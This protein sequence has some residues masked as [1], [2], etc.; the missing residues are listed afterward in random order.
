MNHVCA[1]TP[2]EAGIWAQ[3]EFGEAELGNVMRR[4]RLLAMASRAFERPSGVVSEVIRNPTEQEAA[5]RFLRSKHTDHQEIGRSAFCATAVRCKDEKLVIVPVDGTN[6]TVPWAHG[7][8]AF[9]PVG[10]SAQKVRGVE[11]MSAIALTEAGTPLGICGQQWWVRRDKDP[12]K[13]AESLKLRPFHQKETRY[14]LSCM[15]IS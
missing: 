6:I 4:E 7:T 10:T 15:T 2:I 9:G 3:E 5:Y 1:V 11:T 13:K 14:W 8:T 12:E